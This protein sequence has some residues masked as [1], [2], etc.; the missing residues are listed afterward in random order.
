[1]AWGYWSA[2][3]VSD[4]GRSPRREKDKSCQS[5]YQTP[6]EVMGVQSCSAVQNSDLGLSTEDTSQLLSGQGGGFYTYSVAAAAA[7]AV[8]A[9]KRTPSMME[10]AAS[11]GTSSSLPNEFTLSSGLMGRPSASNYPPSP[12]SDSAEYEQPHVMGM[13]YAPKHEAH[14]QDF[15]HTDAMCHSISTATAATSSLDR[16]LKGHRSL[17]FRRPDNADDDGT[18]IEQGDEIIVPEVIYE[19]SRTSLTGIGSCVIH[20]PCAQPADP[21]TSMSSLAS[22]HYPIAPR[23][24][25]AMQARLDDIKWGM[26]IV[27]PRYSIFFFV[28]NV[29]LLSIAS[30]YQF[31]NYR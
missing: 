4:R 8:A 26:F 19:S 24:S 28:K 3:S 23:P 16:R 20:G 25:Y 13:H 12:G 9:G 5:Q 11:T 10:G 17:R 14:C 22:E 29:N 31:S 2:T 27:F 30:A 1:M 18:D 7:A 6:S 21:G 15:V